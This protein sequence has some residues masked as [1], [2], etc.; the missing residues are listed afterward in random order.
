M[1]HNLILT[2]YKFITLYVFSQYQE[3]HEETTFIIFPGSFNM[4]KYGVLND[5]VFS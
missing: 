1:S 5:F 2:N 3:W 4:N